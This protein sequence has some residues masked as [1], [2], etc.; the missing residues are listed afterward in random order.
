[1]K[2]RAFKFTEVRT[3]EIYQ[4]K[5]HL[6]DHATKRC[7][8]RGLSLHMLKVVLRYGRAFTKQGYTFYYCVTKQIPVPILKRIGKKINDL[9]I[10]TNEETST[11]VTCYWSNQ[12]MISI[13]KKPNYLRK[14][15]A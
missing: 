6:T 1:M 14:S 10:V 11:V 15:V 5:Y 9:V 3:D 12:G 13:R 7:Q 2:R 8:Q 4:L